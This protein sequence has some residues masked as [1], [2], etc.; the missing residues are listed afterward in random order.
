[1]AAWHGLDR[2]PSALLFSKRR[3]KQRGARYCASEASTVG[4][5]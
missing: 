3:F 5:G 1:M 4:P 2:Y